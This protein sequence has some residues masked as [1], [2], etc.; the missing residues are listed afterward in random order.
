MQPNTP[1]IL[2]T[3]GLEVTFTNECTQSIPGNWSGK[4]KRQKILHPLITV[5]E[6]MDSTA[7]LHYRGKIV[8]I[9]DDQQRLLWA[10][11]SSDAVAASVSPPLRI[12]DAEASSAPTSITPGESPPSTLISRACMQQPANF[13]RLCWR[14]AARGCPACMRA[15]DLPRTLGLTTC[16]PP[17]A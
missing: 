3:D 5:T 12:A 10:P 1:K 2:K 9:T 15:S 14:P 8:R 7:M 16:P 6:L 13:E 4:L 11:A 17:H